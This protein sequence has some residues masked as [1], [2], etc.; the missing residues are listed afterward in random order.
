MTKMFL[1]FI[2]FILG[3]VMFDVVHVI[4][5]LKNQLIIIIKKSFEWY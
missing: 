3:L 5:T 1:L 4:F 2:V